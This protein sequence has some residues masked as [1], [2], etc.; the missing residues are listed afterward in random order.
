[1]I[2]INFASTYTKENEQQDQ[3]RLNILSRYKYLI[4]IVVGVA[5]VGFIDDNSLMRR[6]KY[7]LQ[8]SELKDEIK[9]YNQKNEAIVRRLRAVQRNHKEI[10]KIARERYFM[11]AD[12]EDIFV[13]STDRQPGVDESAE[14][15]DYDETAQ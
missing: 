2:C 5:I 4:T 13:L 7:D 1:M 11:K 6:F 9:A 14:T 8:I 15:N 10:E 3:L 12:D